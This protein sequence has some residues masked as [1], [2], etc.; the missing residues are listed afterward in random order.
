M[1]TIGWLVRFRSKY[2]N[3]TVTPLV[4]CSHVSCKFAYII[5]VEPLILVSMI[6]R[7]EQSTDAHVKIPLINVTLD[8]A[9]AHHAM[10]PPNCI[11]IYKKYIS[12]LIGI[13][14]LYLRSMKIQLYVCDFPCQ[15]FR[16]SVFYCC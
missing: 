6:T 11:N 15:I 7:Q 10:L 3:R 8:I 13:H 9:A 5:L 16:A 2:S 1:C 4:T 14:S 12:V